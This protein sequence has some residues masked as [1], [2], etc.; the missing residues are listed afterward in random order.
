M[1]KEAPLSMHNIRLHLKLNDS[2]RY[3]AIPLYHEEENRAKVL[4]R[5]KGHVGTTYKVYPRGAVDIIIECNKTPFP[6]E[7]DSDVMELFSFVGEVRNTLQEWLVDA[8]SLIV[9]PIKHWRLVHADI[10]KDVKVPE[11]LHLTV[12]NMELSTVDKVLRMYVKN[13]GHGSV[14]RLEE[15]RMFNEAFDD[16]VNSL[17]Q[18]ASSSTASV[19]SHSANPAALVEKVAEQDRKIAMLISQTAE[20]RERMVENRKIPAQEITTTNSA[21]VENDKMKILEV[22]QQQEQQPIAIPPSTT[23][24]YD[25]P[26]IISSAAKLLEQRNTSNNH[27]RI[28]TGSKRLDGLLGGGIERGA[29]TE[30][31]GPVG[32]G[33]TQL[34]LTLSVT[35]QQQEQKRK[36]EE[37]NVDKGCEAITA[38]TRVLFID[39]KKAL[40]RCRVYSIAQARGMDSDAAVACS[41]PTRSS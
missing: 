6:I 23:P 20:M 14:L 15:M 37:K 28:S 27:L 2:K 34:C 19:F 9:P 38:S 36:R 18:G 24:D 41:T 10:N 13:L 11:R 35:A 29:V 26:I 16:A 5:R 17:R 25:S 32:T 21:K 7:T 40:D 22:Q 30:I 3:D 8:K 31:A 12:P 33:K 39:M 1:L 4:R